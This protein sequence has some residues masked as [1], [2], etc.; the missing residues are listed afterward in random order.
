MRLFDSVA[1]EWQLFWIDKLSHAGN[2]C[3]RLCVNRPPLAHQGSRRNDL[4]RIEYG[5]LLCLA[6]SATCLCREILASLCA[7]QFGATVPVARAGPG[8]VQE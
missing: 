2:V 7:R 5:S 4:I 3:K 8:L 6:R 1:R